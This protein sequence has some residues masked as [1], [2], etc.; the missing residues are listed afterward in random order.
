MNIEKYIESK[1]VVLDKMHALVNIAPKINKDQHGNITYSKD[2]KYKTLSMQLAD[3][4][5]L[6]HLI[7]NPL[8]AETVDASYTQQIDDIATAL[9]IN[10]ENEEFTDLIVEFCISNPTYNK[11]FS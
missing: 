1:R 4:L 10:R 9:Y 3:E 6:Y 7:C 2:N 11:L 5:E 8:Y